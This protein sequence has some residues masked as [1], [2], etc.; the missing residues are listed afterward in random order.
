MTSEERRRGRRERRMAKREE[1]RKAS[2]VPFEAVVDPNN[3]YKAFKRSRKE[4]SWKESVQRYEMNLL[5]N[6]NDTVKRLRAGEDITKGFVEFDLW[7]RGR[8]RH[9]KSIHIYERVAQKCFCTEVLIP[10]IMPTLIYDNSA[11]VK[12]KGLHF[13][14]RRLICHLSRFYRKNGFSNDGY[15]LSIDFSKYF[16]RVRHDL[17][18]EMQEEIIRDKKSMKLFRDFV[19]PFGN[20]VS[21]GLGSEVSQISA[22]FYPSRK[23]DHFVKDALRLKYY[24]RY[25]DDLYIIHQSREFLAGCLEKIKGKCA[26][27]G[28]MINEKKTRII[29]LKDGV[30][31][32][33]GVYSLMGT[34]KIVRRAMPA[35]R[36]QMRRKLVKFMRFSRAGKMPFP[37][38]LCSYRAWRGN[39][40]KRYNA[41][42]TVRRMDSFFNRLFVFN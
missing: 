21:L 29:K 19:D 11:T 13:A 7:E 18:F 37:D 12:G 31:F 30:R 27:L 34:G 15:C 22:I 32:L 25:M 24:G 2:H 26:E 16:D 17:L 4:V 9:I 6:L 10:M 5:R 36:K 8:L 42:Y 33:K 14:I 41:Y 38:I 40:L 39:Y 1:K 20:G 35:S 23:L 3:L 28:I